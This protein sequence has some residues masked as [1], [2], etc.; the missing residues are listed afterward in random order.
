MRFRAECQ[1]LIIL[2]RACRLAHD[3]LHQFVGENE[4]HILVGVVELVGEEVGDV[5]AAI[6]HPFPE[7]VAICDGHAAFRRD[8]L[9]RRD[10]FVH[11][12]ARHALLEVGGEGFD[13]LARYLG[14]DGVVHCVGGHID[15]FRARLLY[16]LEYLGQVVHVLLDAR[17]AVVGIVESKADHHEVGRVGKDVPLQSTNAAVGAAAAH[18]C[19]DDG[20]GHGGVQLVKHSL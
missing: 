13:R 11:Q 7:G 16:L 9:S 15:A 20:E 14:T 5:Y 10:V 17:F 12:P 2:G 3:R 1:T 4:V 6:H 18:P 8:S 19:V